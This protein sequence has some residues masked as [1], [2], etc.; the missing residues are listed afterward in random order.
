MPYWLMLQAELLSLTVQSTPPTGLVIGSTTGHGGTTNY[1]LPGVGYG[2]SV[3]L[4]APAADP[5]GYTFSKWTVNGVNQTAGLKNI[6]PTTGATSTTSVA[7]YTTNTYAL[8]VQSTPPTGLSIGSGTGDGGTT[9][10]T[11]PSVAYATNVDLVAPAADPTGYTFAYWTL[12]GTPQTPGAKE[13]TPTMPAMAMTA[14]AVYTTNTY[15][16]AVQSTP[17]TG[18]G[19]GSATGDDGTTNYTVPSVAYAT[20]V[21]LVAPAIDPPGYTFSCWTLNGTPQDPGLK[22]ITLTMPAT[23]MTAVAVYMTNTYTLAVQSMPPT[24]LGI[25]SGTGDGGTTNYMVPSVAYGTSVDLVAPAADPPGYTFSCWTLNGTPQTAGA[26]GN[27]AHDARDSH[28]GSGGVHLHVD[29]T[30]HAADWDRYHFQYEYGR[31]RHDE[32]LGARHPVWD[33]RELG[34]PGGGPGR[35][36]LLAVDADSDGWAAVHSIRGVP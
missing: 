13:I 8:T 32:L 19:I 33:D 18:L 11:V 15:T 16:L 25:G 31:R 29:R 4:Q 14:V 30:I 9:N 20:S 35:V 3:N 21:D 2:T 23:D 27:H 1:T 6:T 24:G 17:L 5:G 12:N 36:H 26:E 7:T 28:D 22:E 34:G 10:Y